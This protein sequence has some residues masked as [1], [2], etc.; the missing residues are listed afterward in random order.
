MDTDE[1]LPRR[2]VGDRLPQ[3]PELL[4][5]EHQSITTLNLDHPDG[6]LIGDCWR[7]AIATILGLPRDDVPHFVALGWDEDPNTY[8]DLAQ[9]WLEGRGLTLRYW[10]VL[11]Q[12]RPWC[13]F[14]IAAGKSPR[15]EWDH[16][17]VIDADTSG[18]VHDPHPSG[19]GIDGPYTGFEGIIP[20][21]LEVAVFG[22]A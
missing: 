14:L 2:L 10:G 3:R 12:A 16:A 15:G 4:T 21:D 11:E 6:P 22:H 8:H 20:L 17:V 1:H 19:T 18:L 5:Y 7:T 9:A 13:K